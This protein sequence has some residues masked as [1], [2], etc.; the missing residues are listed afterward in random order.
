ML[1]TVSPNRRRYSVEEIVAELERVHGRPRL[2]SRFDPMEE[3]ISCILSQHTTD[4]NSFPAF[5]RL[6]STFGSWQEVVD[7]GP[8]K[9]EEVVRSA[10]LGSQKAKHIIGSLTEIKN[11]TGE[12]SLN[13]LR[14]MP[15]LE[16]RE[17]LMTLSGVGPKTASIVLCFSLGEPAIPV[18]THV[19]RVSWRLGLIKQD[20]GEGKAHDKLLEIVP[21]DLAFRFHVALIQHGRKI[22]KA[23]TPLCEECTLKEGCRMYN[24]VKTAPKPTKPSKTNQKPR[25]VQRAKRTK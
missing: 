1:Q 3:L 7:A 2:I 14:G 24:T 21:P 5:T 6:L 25:T 9:V 10:G 4:A 18:D 22:C 19:Y 17:W 8:V 15:M 23:P 11:R 13:A 20:L 16:A 12:Y